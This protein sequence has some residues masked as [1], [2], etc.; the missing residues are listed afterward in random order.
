MVRTDPSG[1]GVDGRLLTVDSI[2]L[3]PDE[4]DTG[5]DELA[6]SLKV[7]AYVAPADQG[8]TGGATPT[9][10]APGAATP[11]A[12]PPAATTPTPTAAVTP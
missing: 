12:V 11:A 10:P 2:D 5:T 6:V 1:V 8:A 9:T 4:A 7:T 3:H